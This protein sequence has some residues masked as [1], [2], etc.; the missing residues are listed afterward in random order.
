MT[1]F[2]REYFPCGV[3]RLDFPAFGTHYGL[4]LREYIANEKPDTLPAARKKLVKLR[5]VHYSVLVVFYG[6]IVAFAYAL[7]S[8]WF[9]I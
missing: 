3:K 7:L 8:R 5:I 4:G 1:P 2:D 9:N 6:L